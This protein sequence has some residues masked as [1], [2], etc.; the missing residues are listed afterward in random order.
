MGLAGNYGLKVVIETHK[1][2]ETNEVLARLKKL[3]VE[4]RAVLML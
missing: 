2:T 3:E 4:A 1:L